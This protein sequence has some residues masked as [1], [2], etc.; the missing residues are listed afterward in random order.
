MT[1]NDIIWGFDDER[2]D[3]LKIVLKKVNDRCLIL[4]LDG[5][6]DTYNSLYFQSRVSK[7]IVAGFLQLIFDC[8]KLT[9]ISS[10]GIGSFSVFLKN[11]KPQGGEAVL[12]HITP[13]AYEVFHLLGFAPFFPIKHDAQ[14][15]IAFLASVP[16]FGVAGCFPTI[17]LCPVCKHKMN[18]KCTGRYRCLSCKTILSVD[19][20]ANVFLG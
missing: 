5:Y 14:E 20:N 19:S 7:A 3:S 6:I 10:T 16:E 9:Y 11:I 13:K 18:I 1:N 17:I 12:V 8:E 4:F 15:A 2:D